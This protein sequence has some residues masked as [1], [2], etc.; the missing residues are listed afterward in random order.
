MR[1]TLQSAVTFS[2]GNSQYCAGKSA[3]ANLVSAYGW[4]ITD[5]GYN[6]PPENDFV[7]TVKTDNAGTSTSHAVHHP[8]HRHGL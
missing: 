1:K 2:G 8:H 4:V 6:C 3:S 5:G 7:I